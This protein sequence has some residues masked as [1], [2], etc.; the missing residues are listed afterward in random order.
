MTIAKHDSSFEAGIRAVADSIPHLFWINSADGTSEYVNQ[1][2]VEYT[3]LTLEKM[4]DVQFASFLHPDDVEPCQIAWGSAL[5]TG[6]V[7]EI[8]LRIKRERDGAF[9]W[10]LVRA[11]PE[12]EG[13]GKVT[14]WFGTLT[15]IDDQKRL[16]AVNAN[17]TAAQNTSA[18]LYESEAKFRTVFHKAPLGIAIVG[19]DG[20]WVQ[21]NETIC[22]ILGYTEAELRT[23]TFAD[24]THPDDR[25]ES[26]Q[27]SIDLRQ[28]KI[29]NADLEK[30]YVHRQGHP[31]WVRV[32]VS[33]LR[34]T[35]GVPTHFVAQMLD[36]TEQ[37]RVNGELIESK[38]FLNTVLDNLPVAL[39]CKDGARGFGFNIWNKMATE[40]W[41]L[42]EEAV[43]G[44]TDYDF[45]PKDQADYFREKDIAVMAGGVTVDIPEERVDTPDKGTLVLHTK[46]VPVA[47]SDGTPRFLLG[48]SEDITMRKQNE[49][50]IEAQRVRLVTAEKMTSLGVMAAGVAHEINNP[51][52]I[53]AG[54]VEQIQNALKSESPDKSRI[55]KLVTVIERTIQRISQIVDG[56]QFFARDGSKDAYAEIPVVQILEQTLAF[57]QERLKNHGIRL[58]LLPIAEELKLWCQPTQVSQILLNLLNN[59]HDAILPLEEKWVRIQFLDRED[60]LELIVEDSGQGIPEAIAGKIFEPFFTTKD[61]GKGTGLGLSIS[62]GIVDSH[63]GK[64]VLD[65]SSK[66]TR[67]VVSLPKRPESGKV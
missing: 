59:A 2:W 36:I 39:F 40:T 28:G 43:M 1:R 16:S 31:I 24:I 22:R 56:L 23:M 35:A 42:S 49:A 52:A 66:N 64:M 54:G 34:D 17:L 62:K 51:L 8:E 46:K 18:A 50:I 12:R 48:I 14:R 19:L 61:I 63:R 15:D 58:E 11:L 4:Q 10:F 33:L 38:L 29:A 6:Q 67:F 25:A 3:G 37:K 20:R 57:C 55:T 65:R 9:R 13:G 60:H 5:K 7:Y 53:I 45:F 41:G 26:Q 30:R 21:A 44:K 47:G 27:A 32:Y